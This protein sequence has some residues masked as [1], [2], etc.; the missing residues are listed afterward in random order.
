MMQIKPE[1]KRVL[2]SRVTACSLCKFQ[3]REFLIATSLNP[4]G[5]WVLVCSHCG[6]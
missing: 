5:V 1:P 2:G 3:R 6:T 4:E